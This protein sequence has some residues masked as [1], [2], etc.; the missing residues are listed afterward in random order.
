[1]SVE[2]CPACRK[3]VGDVYLLALDAK[4][5]AECFRCALCARPIIAAEFALRRDVPVHRECFRCDRCGGLIG[6]RYSERDGKFYCEADSLE[7]FGV[8]CAVCARWI[9]GRYLTNL[10]G[11]TY[12]SEHVREVE[13]CFSCCRPVCERLTRGGRRYAD[14]RLLCGLCLPRAVNGE[15]EAAKVFG[16]VRWILENWGLR[17]GEARFPVMTA[18]LEVLKGSVGSSAHRPLGVTQK[19]ILKSGGQVIERA[20]ERI[21]VLDG[22]PAVH[23]AAVAAHELGHA[24]LCLTGFPKLPHAVEEGFSELCA[25]RWLCV[26]R[27]EESRVHLKGM[28]N[29]TDPIY[30]DGFRAA[31]AAYA[32]HGLEKTLAHLREAGAFPE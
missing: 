27:S 12:C 4:W 17:L 7:L 31:R 13:L 15:R 3:P 32:K 6:A 9:E 28:Q 5:H 20:V 16:E 29:N 30:G 11:D 21:I 18:D 2:L 23:F 10:W 14:G 8:R 19:R 26:R 22:L 25:W 1:M 24:Y